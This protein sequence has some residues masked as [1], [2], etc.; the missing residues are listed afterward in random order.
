MRNSI[1]ATIAYYDILD[2]PLD[3][4]EIYKYM[5]NPSRVSILNKPITD[6]TKVDIRKEMD[7]LVKLNFLNSKNSLYFLPGRQ[8]ICDIREKRQKIA[9]KKW[10]KFLQISKWLE[11]VPYIRGV[12]ASGSMAMDNTDEDSDFDVLVIAQPGR[13]YTAR[14][15]L[16]LLTSAM[17]VRRRWFDIKAPDKLCFNHYITEDSLHINH[18]SLYN[19]Q[20][21]AH[22]KPILMPKE[23]FE[24]FFTA[25]NWINKYL[26]NFRP[27]NFSRAISPNPILIGLAKFLELIL[28]TKLGNWLE[29]WAK[30]YQQGR[31]EKNPSTKNSGGRIIYNDHEL[32]FH[33]N[34]FE[35]YLINQYNQNITR[36]GISTPFKEQDSGLTL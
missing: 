13:L 3:A 31:I 11:P 14:L 12:F 29:N 25:N 9:E 6:F 27:N 32:E 17:R 19:A 18:H 24:K 16:L 15:L 10:A 36:L 1:L 20:S 4:E 22:L 2:F 23:L 21:Y 30:R 7:N 8:K 26:Y 35:K 33:P 34:S 5:I 28:N